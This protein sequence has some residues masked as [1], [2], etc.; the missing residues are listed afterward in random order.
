MRPLWFQALQKLLYAIEKGSLDEQLS[1]YGAFSKAL[2]EEGGD[3]S[4]YI[5]AV[6]SKKM[7]TSF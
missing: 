4:A 6:L 7:K 5:L 1:Y 2:Y 3:L